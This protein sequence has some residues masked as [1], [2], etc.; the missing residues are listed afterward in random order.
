MRETSL[1]EEGLNRNIIAGFI[2]SGACLVICIQIPCSDNITV[3]DVFYLEV[4]FEQAL[5][6]YYRELSNQAKDRLRHF[7]LVFTFSTISYI[8]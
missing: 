5:L 2:V 3:L 4:L 1:V 8:N 6:G 7:K